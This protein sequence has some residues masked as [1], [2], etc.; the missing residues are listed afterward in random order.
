M[1]KEIERRFLL[2]LPSILVGRT[3]RF[4][5]QGYLSFSPVT[6][7]VRLIPE[8]REAFL[9]LKGPRVGIE[10]DEFEYPIPFEDG[11]QLL[12]LCGAHIVEKTRY[13]VVENGHTFEVDVVH[14]RH[15]GLYMVELELTDP[16]ANVRIPDWVGEEIS[17]DFRYSNANLAVCDR[18]IDTPPGDAAQFNIAAKG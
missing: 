3:G 18:F 7:R 11:R 17:G 6:T 4:M 14:G 5:V 13:E 9:T 8:S 15:D 1:A 2:R 16:T 10:C 12:A